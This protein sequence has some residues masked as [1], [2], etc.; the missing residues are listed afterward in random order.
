MSNNSNKI[1]RDFENEVRYFLKNTLGFSDVKGGL[2]FHM[3]PKR[4]SNQ[5]DVAARYKDVLFVFECKASGKRTKKD[6]RSEILKYQAKAR[7]VLDGYKNIPEYK[8]CK[9]VKFIFITKNIT[10]TDANKEMIYEDKLLWYADSEMLDYYTELVDKIGEY[11][12]YNFLA[13]HGIRPSCDEF[14]EVRAIREKIGDYLVYSF[15]AKPKEL[16]KISYVARRRSTK[17]NFYQRLLDVSR[18]KKIQSFVESGGVFPTNIILSIKNGE[19]NFDSNAQEDNIGKLTIKGS[20]DACWIVD[21]Q[22]RLYSFA[23]SKKD[24][25]IP[26]IAFQELSIK[27]ERRF[28]LEINKEQKPIPSDLIWDLEGL[29]NPKSKRGVISNI[30]R[31]LNKREPFLD[32]IYIPVHGSKKGKSITMTAFCNGILNSTITNDVTTNCHGIKNPLYDDNVPRMTKRVADV[33]SRFF[34]NISESF[35]NEHHRKFLLGN[36]GVPILLYLLE[37]IIADIGRV[38]S[39]ADFTEYID[40]I[41]DFFEENYPD[42]SDIKNLRAETTSEGSRKNFAKEV[43]KYIKSVLGSRSRFWSKMEEDDLVQ[44]IITMERRIGSFIAGKLEEVSPSW[45]KRCIP[46]QIRQVAEERASRD[47]TPFE[48]NLTLGDELNIINQKGNWSDVFKSVFLSNDAFMNLEEL[49]VA[50]QYLSKVRNPKLH[51]KSVVI[52][53]ND[54]EQCRIYLDK[55]NKIIPDCE[56]E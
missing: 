53:K 26:C 9:F 7:L 12:I 2:D 45:K 55:F 34:E 21:G 54:I 24:T 56:E 11:A 6:L 17:E 40:P 46:Q 51:G 16:L 41:V 8:S 28:F 15:F 47:N 32:K 18:I 1:G 19:V 33:L 35:S 39:Y 50:F 49:R 31:T 13:D 22:H 38:P 44:D 14:F 48:E 43:G 4:Q 37:P 52:S 29:S 42:Y 10:I 30:V 3:S 27:E 20:Y 23:K 25:L 36:A 5:I